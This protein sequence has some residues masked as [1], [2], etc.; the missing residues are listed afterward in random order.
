[1]PK[2]QSQNTEN[3]ESVAKIGSFFWAIML[4][5]AMFFGTLWTNQ[6]LV[7]SKMESVNAEIKKLYDHDNDINSK[8]EKINSD[9]KTLLLE[10]STRLRELEIKITELQVKL[11]Y[12]IPNEQNKS[13]KTVER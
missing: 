4:S 5:A 13:I 8:I 9:Q 11:N 1:M 6:A 12:I 10:I 2:V 7:N 3:M